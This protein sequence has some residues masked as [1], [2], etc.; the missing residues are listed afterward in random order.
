ME[1]NKR[2][3]EMCHAHLY[4][5]CMINIKNIFQKQIFGFEK[6]KYKDDKLNKKFIKYI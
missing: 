6:L 3:V 1:S 2:E 4:S 5:A